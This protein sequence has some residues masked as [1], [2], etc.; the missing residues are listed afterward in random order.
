MPASQCCVI[1]IVLLIQIL[2]VVVAV[3]IQQK[4]LRVPVDSGAPEHMTATAL[5]EVA[6]HF[7]LRIYL[8]THTRVHVV[9]QSP[10]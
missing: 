9:I 7:A 3:L 4:P 5:V 1:I 10:V 6:V 2:Q 8:Q